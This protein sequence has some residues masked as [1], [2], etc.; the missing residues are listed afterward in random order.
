[1]VN[2][3]ILWP[4]PVETASIK[5]SISFLEE[6]MVVNELLSILLGERIERVI[7]TL[8]LTVELGKSLGDLG[9]NLSSSLILEKTWAK[10]EFSQVSSNSNSSGLDH[11]GLLWWEVWS[12]EHNFRVLSWVVVSFLVTVIVLDNLVH[13]WGEHTVG[14]MTSSVD[15]DT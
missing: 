7:L 9:L 12:V 2:T 5:E 14:I 1:M 11:L 3:S 15:T 13:Q 4:V 8:Q 10:W 6:E